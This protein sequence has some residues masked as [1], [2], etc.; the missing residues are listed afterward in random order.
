MNEVPHSQLS[1]GYVVKLRSEVS[2]LVDSEIGTTMAAA[3]KQFSSAFL[4]LEV[5]FCRLMGL[6]LL[7][8]TSKGC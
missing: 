7:S 5:T 4:T 1:L 6:C 8:S 3:D 2:L